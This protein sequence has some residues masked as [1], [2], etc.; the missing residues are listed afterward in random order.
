MTKNQMD[1][2]KR[3]SLDQIT[4]VPDSIISVYV[5]E[6]HIWA[7]GSTPEARAARQ[8][9]RRTIE[10]FLL[11]PVRSFLNDIF[12]QMA[13]PY[14]PQRKDNPIGQG[15]WIQA[16]F[17][18]GKS[19][20]LSFIGA[21]A[22]AGEDEWQLVQDKEKQAGLG[23]RESLYNFYENGLV[24]KN[25]DSKGIFVA[26]KTLVG[27]GGGGIGLGDTGKDLT[28]YILDAVADQFFLETG[29]SL[30]LYPTE[31]LAERFL[32][33]D[34]FE[35]YRR[36]L[37]KFLQDPTYFDEEAQE[38]INQFL[39]NLQNNPDP[40]IRRD[41]GQRLWE[42]YEHYLNTRPKIPMETED[43]LK[44][45]V[46]SLLA[47]GYA[48]LLLILDEVSLF[49]RSRSD[50]QRFEDEKA[51]V[52]LSNR[53]AKVE[54]LP[55][56]TVCAAQQAIETRMA[57][58][59]NIIARE[60]LD[61]VPLLNNQDYYYDIALSRVR[62]ITDI[63]AVDQYYEDYQRSFSWPQA[64]GRDRFAHFFPF[65]PPS[66]DVVRAVSYNLTTVR[67]ALYFMLQTLK[68]QRKRKSKELITLWSLFDDV[69]E[70]E[71]D[72]SGTTKGIANI[73]TK[74][75][76][77][78][79]AYET[80]KRQLDTVTK[81]PLKVYRSR[82]EKIIRTLFLYHTANLAPNG[83]KYE[84]LMNSVMEWKD[85]AREQ[86]ADLQD[87]LD[88]YEILTDKL[89]L[90]LAQVVR[91]GRNYRF[92]PT[93]GGPQPRELFQKARAEAEQDEVARRQAW[94]AL[95]ALN[96]W[97]IRSALM[98]MDLASGIRSLF[99]DIASASQTDLTIKWHGREISGRVYMRDLLDIAKRGAMLPS[100][101]S[102][103]TG[104][105]YA[106]FI[107]STPAVDQLD[108]L[109]KAKQD[110]RV[111]FWSPDA[112][113][114]SEQSLLVDFTAYRTLVADYR[115]QDTQ[116]A[117]VVL[118]WVQN[119]LRDQMGA[120]YRIVPDSYSRGRLAA[121]DHSHMSFICEGEL[122]AIL[123]PLA[124]Q[125]LDA[126]YLCKEMAFDAPAPFND[127]N[128]VNVINGI[129]K[130][131]QIPRGAKPNRDISAAQNYGFDLQIMVHPND[132][133]L[134]LSQC[135]YTQDMANW[136][137]DKLGDGSATM[138]AVSVYKNF[139]G[140]NGPNGL[141]YGLSKRMVQLYLLC[142]AREGKIRISLSGRNMPV[143]AID[144]SN[145]TTIDFKVA[146]LE[147]F[148][149]IQRLKPPEGWEMLAPFA[150]VLLEDNSLRTARQDADIQSG[151]GRLLAYKEE[152]LSSFQ[153]LRTGITRLL[154]DLSLVI[155]PSSLA[156]DQ[157]QMTKDQGPRTN[158]QGPMTNDQGPMTNNQ[159]LLA[160]LEAWETFL[161][162]PTGTDPIPYLC[163][164]LDKAFDYRVYQEEVV[165]P[166]EVDDLASRLAEVKQ[167]ET[168]YQYRE[169][170]RAVARYSRPDFVE[171]LP[172]EPALAS[173]KSVLKRTHTLLADSKKLRQFIAGEVSLLNELLEPAEAAI[174]S[175]SVRY[176]QLFDQV[177]AHTEQVKGQIKA[178]HR[179]ETYLALARLAQVTALGADPRP[180]LERAWRQAVEG[181][182]ELFPATLTHA[183][184]ERELQAM[185]QPPGCPLTIPN[186]GDWLQRADDALNQAQ[187]ALHLALKD[188]A[189]LLHSEALRER[190]KQ[191]Q[192][193]PFI[194]G[195]LASQTVEEM[196]TY[197]RQTLGQPP[198]AKEPITNDHG[199][200]TNDQGPMTND[201]KPMTNDQKPMTNDQEPMTNDPISLLNRYLKQIRIRKLRLT[202]FIPGKQTIE[203]GDIDQIVTEFR[204]FL[205]AALRTD[206]DDELPVVELE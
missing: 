135:R 198:T 166:E 130:V 52:V 40:G 108:E 11:D 177:T 170:L 62:E 125:V 102:A 133:K 38:D 179:R 71:E 201:Q 187:T 16:E 63:G 158:D 68:T 25:Q 70:Y 21:L 39:D 174:K 138:P 50:K 150:A 26:V 96:G 31:I 51:L 163:N 192:N 145:I 182:P 190:L 49:M 167:L 117:K 122:T 18:S 29:K 98:T 137:N 57:G 180:E 120:I 183:T 83:L 99:R 74:W 206:S 161:A 20:L 181:P 178:L 204:Q 132:R 27:Q 10:E 77:A 159:E 78:W 58:V 79:Q 121:A 126:I 154:E 94:E 54:N 95:L 175:Y 156:D 127:T 152:N 84:D 105:D 64:V 7:N 168:F 144:Y 72:P 75:P 101:N 59:K 67:S 9:E 66:I 92:E 153:T 35:R 93:G 107:S 76:E 65:Y 143:E 8:V 80:A 2:F 37:A 128:A 119:R 48:G 5:V 86:R 4:D 103:E 88:H 118:D 34:D 55:V 165:Y 169:R 140:T 193:E 111:L 43:I 146:V 19:H 197:L 100:I 188:K 200:M 106:V 129:V 134:D 115:G 196:T 90:E 203:A 24:K 6:Q 205:L 172:D 28:E 89:A 131:G 42:F 46:K 202:D 184:I 30:P 171:T 22:L 162:A 186:A 82:C 36:D 164:A 195:L 155:P 60:R 199:P 14:V 113:T 47:E 12:R 185:P 194:A 69:V 3:P 73:K 191:G 81:G 45:M 13:A 160:R 176:R 104:L 173:I 85:H 116:E 148:D 139:M 136:I 87:N 17:G 151:V 1:L 61:L 114:D 189:A 149:Q 23:R 53:L 41:C 33:T 124:G 56:W 110:P 91:V 123:T 141:H 112:L 142:L 32:N 157:T 147:A 44:H 15:Y 109:I 97:E